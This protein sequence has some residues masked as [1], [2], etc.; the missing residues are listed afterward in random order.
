MLVAK[1]ASGKMLSAS[2]MNANGQVVVLNQN[3][4]LVKSYTPEEI[5]AMK[6]KYLK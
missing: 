4:E 5:Q 3:L 6:A 2:L 1:D